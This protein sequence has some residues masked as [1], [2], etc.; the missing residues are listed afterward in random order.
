MLLVKTY[1]MKLSTPKWLPTASKVFAAPAVSSGAPCS[2]AAGL[3]DLQTQRAHSLPSSLSGP[4]K[5]VSAYLC[6]RSAILNP[7]A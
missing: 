3:W 1:T 2:T 4:L 5:K 6:S 7:T